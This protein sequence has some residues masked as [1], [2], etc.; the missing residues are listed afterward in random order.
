MEVE[1]CLV[2]RYYILSY[3]YTLF[4]SDSKRRLRQDRKQMSPV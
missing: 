3:K 2:L 1:L 4:A